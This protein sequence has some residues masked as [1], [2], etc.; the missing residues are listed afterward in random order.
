M[1]DFSW[2]KLLV[3]PIWLLS[4]MLPVSGAVFTREAPGAAHSTYSLQAEHAAEPW[5]EADEES[6]YT[7]D[8]LPS[9]PWADSVL[10]IYLDGK[11][12]ERD[13]SPDGFS[14][15]GLTPGRHGIE[16]RL[17]S[18]QKELRLCTELW[19]LG[20]VTVS[21]LYPAEDA[22]VRV[23]PDGLQSSAAVSVEAPGVS[24]SETATVIRHTRWFLDDEPLPGDQ[25]LQQQ[26]PAMD[27]GDHTL[28]FEIETVFGGFASHE[29]AFV[30]VPDIL[31]EVIGDTPGPY[32]IRSF[33]RLV[34]QAVVQQPRSPGASGPAPRE[35]PFAQSIP[36]E[37]DIFWYVD[38]IL[39]DRGGEFLFEADPGTY[40]IT[41]EYLVDS[42]SVVPAIRSAPIQV[43]VREPIGARIIAPSEPGYPYLGTFDGSASGPGPRLSVS[44]DGEP[45]AGFFWTLETAEGGLLEVEG[46]DATFDLSRAGDI[47][48]GML[49][50][51]T[52]L[53]RWQDSQTLAFVAWGIPGME[54]ELVC[55]QGTGVEA[56]R[57]FPVMTRLSS[58]HT[59]SGGRAG[60][61]RYTYSLDGIH[62][63][64]DSQAGANAACMI[65]SP[66]WHVIRVVVHDASGHAAMAE[67]EVFAYIPWDLKVE[68]GGPFV[69]RADDVLSLTMG[70]QPSD[71]IPQ[72]DYWWEIRPKVSG[73]A[74][75]RIEGRVLSFCFGQT[76]SAEVIGC[77]VS[78]DGTLELE[79][80]ADVT[81]VEGLPPL[82]G[83]HAMGSRT[84]VNPGD[85]V[86]ISAEVSSST[87]DPVEA[88]L[89]WSR[90]GIAQPSS[91]DASAL[92]FTAGSPGTIEE[93]SCTA[94]LPSG[95]SGTGV[96]QLTVNVPPEGFSVLMSPEGPVIPAPGRVELSVEGAVDPDDDLPLT[97]QWFT[98][99]AGR[100]QSL[101]PQLLDGRWSANLPAGGNSVFV[102]V[103]D[104]LQ[105]SAES[106]R[107][108]VE[109][110]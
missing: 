20:E 23:G 106:Q 75:V 107:L 79:G 62:P 109:V 105:L 98:L 29:V 78:A 22:V 64:A 52:V 5:I 21:I 97:Y 94:S 7:I 61:F 43:M 74:P 19:V 38:G 25:H 1:A 33:E 17:R 67:A 18:R 57:A 68:P 76:G 50:L 86:M 30:A 13:A 110:R 24:P 10:S 72:G 55:P 104:S 91:D 58:K 47:E 9:G 14:I 102:R 71:R 84:H 32:A 28:R 6:W 83:L 65:E 77:F 31:L 103:M 89:S 99:N 90:N 42:S 85:R 60:P 82:V 45:D 37:E 59:V 39:Q 66:G 16:A 63:L 69:V 100:L 81:V 35:Q 40:T 73:A 87:G 11:L 70:L 95:S 49:T 53:D 36:R 92:L 41:S 27:L 4:F 56:G 15:P 44:G 96:L 80:S 8:P 54:V 108:E 51:T 88:N 3:I 2:A 48:G 46:R 34:F 12:H 93:I 26:L 101:S